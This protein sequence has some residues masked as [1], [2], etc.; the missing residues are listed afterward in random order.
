MLREI[1][2]PDGVPGRLFRAPMPGGWGWPLD[3]ALREIDANDIELVVCLVTMH[4]IR[5]EAPKYAREIEDED[6]PWE[7]WDI[8]L[9]DGGAPEDEEEFLDVA[10]D[11]AEEL[12]DGAN[13]L[14]HC[15]AGIGRTGMLAACTLMALGL[16][17]DDALRAIEEAGAGPE[18]AEQ[19]RMV[20]WAARALKYDR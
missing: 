18:T 4:E 13:V 2:L 20:D 11:L 15:N 10:R 6:L 9:P 19:L 17:K 12:R 16:G 1:E 7:M 14:I 5:V 3:K 8:P